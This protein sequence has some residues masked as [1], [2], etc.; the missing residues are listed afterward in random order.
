[1]KKNNLLIPV[2]EIQ[3]FCMHDGPGVRT[4]VFFKGCPLRCAWCH[5]PETQQATQQLLYYPQ[6]CI[7]CGACITVCPHGA[8]REQEGLH[9]FDRTRCQGCLSCVQACCSGAL[10]PSLKEMTLEEILEIVEKDRPFYGALGGITLSGGEPM[11]HPREALA[12]LEECRRRGIGTAMETCGYFDGQYLPALVPLVD[13]FLW[14]FKDGNPARHKEYTGVD[15]ARIREQLLRVDALGGASILRCILVK[16]VN[17]Q[18]DH[19]EAIASLWHSLEHCRQVELLPYH[20]YGGS[21]MIP[22]GLEDNG[23]R[24]WIPSDED[25]ET[26]KSILIKKGVRLK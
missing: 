11:A 17:M 2:T 3:R 25:M 9:V 6:K 19:Y 5:N 4:T 20:A 26:A 23:H 10:E 12:L 22:L 14:D 24:E 1:M 7:G 18:E 13:L 8:H 16:G 15:N 21:K